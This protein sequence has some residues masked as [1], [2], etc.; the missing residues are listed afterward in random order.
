M[1]AVMVRMRRPINDLRR[2]NDDRR[3]I[4]DDRRRYT[5]TIGRIVA[6]WHAIT[7]MVPITAIAVIAAM[8]VMTAIIRMT[9]CAGVSTWI[10]AVMARA[11]AMDRDKAACLLTGVRKPDRIDANHHLRMSHAGT[12]NGPDNASN[13]RAFMATKGSTNKRTRT[14]TEYGTTGY[15]ARLDRCA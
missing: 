13:R 14:R 1:M 3:R 6:L 5:I 2:R 8:V 10:S 4:S 11:P 7:I 9:I 12:G 15:V